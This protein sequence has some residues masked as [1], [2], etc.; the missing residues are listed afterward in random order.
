MNSRAKDDSN[1]KIGE[2]PVIEEMGTIAEVEESHQETRIY[3]KRYCILVMFVLLSASNAMQWIEYSIIAHIIVHFYSVSYAAVD[4]TSMIYML[5]YIIFVIPASWILDKYGLR[6][7]VLLGA[8]GNCLGAWIKTLSTNPHSFWITFVGQTIVGSSQMFI[9]G[10]PPRLAAVWFG[11][12]QVSTACAAGVFGNQLGIAIGFVVPPLLVHM[13]KMESIAADLKLLFLISAVTNSI[14]L[15][16]IFFFFSKQPPLPPSL[17]QLQS[18]ERAVDKNYVSSLKQLAANPNYLLLLITYGINVGVFYAVSTLLSQMVLHY[19]PEEQANIG[20]IGLLIV[21]AGMVGSVVC[22]II[23]DKFHRYKLTTVV[24]YLFSFVGMV[25]FTFTIDLGHIWYIFV[26]AALLGF[27]MT[28]SLPIGF[29]FAAELT[30]PIAEGTT[31]GLLNASAQ[32]FGVLM[33]M[34]MGHIIHSVNI[35]VCNVALS[36]FLFVGTVLTGKKIYPY[37]TK[38]FQESVN[39]VS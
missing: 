31:S 15:S 6:V 17:A 1:G 14:I 33:T 22:G 37:Q 16:L 10:I 32:V 12:E 28:G 19:Y 3:R 23:L 5:S 11:P 8:S 4:W 38:V 30:F 20:T 13:G 39:S 24:V 36:A 7:S 25:L 29:E 35:F 26:I 2:F 34:I 21:V 9:L 27:F 18:S